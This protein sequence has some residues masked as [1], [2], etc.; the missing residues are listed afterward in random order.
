MKR[1][2]Y[3]ECLFKRIITS[4]EK[5]GGND[6][7][8]SIILTGSFGRNEPTY[9]LDSGGVIH[10]KSD[11][12][13]ALVY[14][15]CASK[16]KINTIIK[17][18]SC[19]FEEELNLMPINEHRIKNMHNFN[20]T[21]IS[22]KYKTIFTYDL[23]NGSKTIWGKDLI[24]QKC[25]PLE[26]VD[27]YE[28]KRLVANRIAEMVYL[29][30]NSPEDHMFYLKTQWKGKIILAIVS[31]W[32]IC[33]KEYS[34]SYHEQYKK[35][36]TYKDRAESTFGKGFYEDYRKVFCF[37]RE[38]GEPYDIPDEIMVKYIKCTDDYLYDQNIC[39]PK[40]N[41]IS[42]NLKY[43]VKYYKTKS[44][45]G[46]LNFE[47]NILQAIIT[48]YWMKSNKITYDAEIWHNVLY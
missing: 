31:A 8:S 15:Q 11:I 47:D 20:Y 34:S 30:S 16:K 18:V 24:E 1:T 32:L 26:M 39:K 23:F 48:D 13:I 19:E 46:I 42:R 40:V 7:L 17:N 38:C 28:A 14:P 35:F 43:F 3:E 41:S 10:L 6:C 33:E 21:F 25:L 9:A 37:L 22:P 36:E 2:A 44:H 29:Q 4:I 45:Y 12:E 27:M 5:N